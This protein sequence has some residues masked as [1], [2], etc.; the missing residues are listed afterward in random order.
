MRIGIALLLVLLSVGGLVVPLWELLE[1][2]VLQELVSQFGASML[3]VYLLGNGYFIAINVLPLR[4]RP[5]A[6]LNAVSLVLLLALIALGVIE[7][8]HWIFAL[9]AVLISI[10]GWR[11]LAIAR[12][13]RG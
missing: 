12:L 10:I 13:L 2:G 5:K 3:A 11:L 1:S 9:G 6:M 7:K 8:L 4:Y